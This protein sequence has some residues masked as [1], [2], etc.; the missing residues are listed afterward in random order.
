M[1]EAGE[2]RGPI[3]QSCAMPMEQPEQFGT[4]AD[5]SR[6]EEYCCYCFQG[7]HFTA[8]ELSLE[9]MQDKLVQIAVERGLMPE[10]KARELA[11]AVLPTLKR[12]RRGEGDA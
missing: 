6:N 1:T 10:E 11:T 9:Q 7:G 3:C 8:P 4:N 12:W 5:G 2:P